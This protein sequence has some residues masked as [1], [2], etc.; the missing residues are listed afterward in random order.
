ML[1]RHPPMTAAAMSSGP[2]SWLRSDES[3]AHAAVIILEAGLSLLPVCDHER[4]LVGSVTSGDLLVALS[5]G[6]DRGREIREVMN[7]DPPVIADFAGPEWV[8]TE[9]IGAGSWTL[10]VIDAQDCLVAVVT[11]AD[12]APVVSCALLADS[13][14]QIATRSQAHRPVAPRS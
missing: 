13:W 7:P 12:L 9:M 6:M 3:I 4:R 2:P 10:P 8:I 11:L 5:S 14:Q 1:P